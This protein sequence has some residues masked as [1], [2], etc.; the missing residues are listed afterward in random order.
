MTDVCSA[1]GGIRLE[2]HGHSVHFAVYYRAAQLPVSGFREA[3]AL[4]H[5]LSGVVLVQSG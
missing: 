4:A 1:T 2:L 5:N 3:A